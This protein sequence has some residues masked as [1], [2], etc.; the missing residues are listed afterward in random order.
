MPIPLLAHS[1]SFSFYFW[2]ASNF[3]M[4][5]FSHNYHMGLGSHKASFHHGLGSHKAGWCKVYIH[6]VVSP[7]WIYF[8]F[9]GFENLTTGLWFEIDTL[10]QY[11]LGDLVFKHVIWS[12]K[13]ITNL[14]F[15]TCKKWKISITELPSVCKFKSLS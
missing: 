8:S 2:L 12:L 13:K 7:V 14:N 4:L 3:L 5:L 11:H 6:I 15:M 1:N 9:V 10:V